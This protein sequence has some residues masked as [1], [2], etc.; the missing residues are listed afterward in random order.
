MRETDFE[1]AASTDFATGAQRLSGFPGLLGSDNVS[2]VGIRRLAVGLK[3]DEKAFLGTQ[4][5]VI[6]VPRSAAA[7][8]II[9]SRRV[10]SVRVSNARR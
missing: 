6:M 5:R 1:S 8:T 3:A 2:A 9:I 4:N 10:V 7:P